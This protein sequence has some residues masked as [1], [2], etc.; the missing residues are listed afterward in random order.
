MYKERLHNIFT[1]TIEIDT[2]SMYLNILTSRVEIKNPK[3]FA[4]H[5]KDVDI[6]DFPKSMTKDKY[7]ELIVVLLINIVEVHHQAIYLAKS[8]KVLLNEINVEMMMTSKQE[9][10][11]KCTLTENENE[12]LKGTIQYLLGM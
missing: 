12:R 9:E 3:V 5:F 10:V 11:E 6:N 7:K 2:E 4:L 1:N 8:L